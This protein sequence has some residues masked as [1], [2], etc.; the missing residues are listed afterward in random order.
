MAYDEREK[1]RE[2][3]TKIGDESSFVVIVNEKEIR[4]VEINNDRKVIVNGYDNK[5]K[6]K[7]HKVSEKGRGKRRGSKAIIIMINT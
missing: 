3:S 6:C 7:K 4:F 1:N 5:L 2:S